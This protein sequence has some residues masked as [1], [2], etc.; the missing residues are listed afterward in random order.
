MAEVLLYDFQGYVV[1]EKL[2]PG[3]Y[4]LSLS[5]PSL[6]CGKLVTVLLKTFKQPMGRPLQEGA[7]SSTNNQPQLPTHV[8]LTLKESLLTSQLFK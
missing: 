2:L 1:K 6:L 7:E 4:S 5:D 8:L 3:S